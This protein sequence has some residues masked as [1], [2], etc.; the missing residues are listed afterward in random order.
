MIGRRV[1]AEGFGVLDKSRLVT[2]YALQF[3]FKSS[4][5]V[6]VPTT[7]QLRF[8]AHPRISWRVVVQIVTQCS[9]DGASAVGTLAKVEL[10]S[11]NN[12]LAHTAIHT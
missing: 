2:P 8:L 12:G 11:W 9:G 7:P 3:D 10:I 6:T 4:G 5:F 1:F